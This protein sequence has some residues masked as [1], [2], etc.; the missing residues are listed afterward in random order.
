MTVRVPRPRGRRPTVTSGRGPSTGPRGRGQGGD[1]AMA[2]A[3]DVH[4]T[5]VAAPPGATLGRSHSTTRR[6]SDDEPRG[7]ARAPSPG[8]AA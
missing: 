7:G 2:V 4:S 1:L 3:G 6:A 8:A 5:A